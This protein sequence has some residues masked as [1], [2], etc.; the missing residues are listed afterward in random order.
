MSGGYYLN[1]TGSERIGARNITTRIELT[2]EVSWT[3]NYEVIDGKECYFN[4]RIPDLQTI[5]RQLNEMK[6]G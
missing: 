4:K 2:G 5:D 6:A 1:I 3:A